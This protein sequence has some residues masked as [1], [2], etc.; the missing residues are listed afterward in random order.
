MTRTIDLCRESH[1]SIVVFAQRV[2]F[3]SIDRYAEAELEETGERRR[4]PGVAAH[5]ACCGPCGVDYQGLIAAA[6]QGV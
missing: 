5:L 4:F 6:R 1:R 3:Q 2:A